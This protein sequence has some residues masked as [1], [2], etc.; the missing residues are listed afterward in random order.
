MWSLISSWANPMIDLVQVDYTDRGDVSHDLGL[1][2]IIPH[3]DWRVGGCCSPPERSIDGPLQERAEKT[4]RPAPA[5]QTPIAQG[6]P[7][8]A[9]LQLE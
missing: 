5:G 1:G 9:D 2:T 4:M 7:A 6:I 8:L 3:G